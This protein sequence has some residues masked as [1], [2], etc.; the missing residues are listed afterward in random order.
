[1]KPASKTA[2]RTGTMRCPAGTLNEARP[3]GFTLLEVMVSV[4]LIGILLVTLL[5]SLGYHLTIAEKQARVST[6]TLLAKQKMYEV[7]KRPVTGKGVFNDPFGDFRYETEVRESTIPGIS[8]ISV[9]VRSD[10]D[11]VTMTALIESGDRK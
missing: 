2:C 7:E 4:A 8:M 11:V 1:M 10:D 9:H 6:A 5:T 3:P